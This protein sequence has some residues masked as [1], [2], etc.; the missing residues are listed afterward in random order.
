VL[1]WF[2]TLGGS[3]Q[4]RTL[5]SLFFSLLISIFTAA[6]TQA[7][8]LAI[9]QFPAKAAKLADFCPQGW[10]VESKISCD[11]NDDKKADV[12]LQ[13]LSNAP[14][15]KADQVSTQNRGLVVLFADGSGQYSLADFAPKFLLCTTCGGQLG[16]TVE[17][18]AAKECFSV[19]QSG[20][21]GV[22]GFGYDLTFKY[23]PALKKFVVSK[24]E[25]TNSSDR[26]GNQEQTTLLDFPKS[27]AVITKSNGEKDHITRKP[28]KPRDILLRSL[29]ID[30]ISAAFK[31]FPI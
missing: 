27:V 13:L 10:Q 20:G 8:D 18:T 29:D 17:M 6:G 1:S 7:K 4:L 24:A 23:S 9:A 15:A 12:V 26:P 25:F 14:A 30:T 2:A 16:A 31:G 3:L 5:S 11:L 22:D 28:I 19:S 21:G